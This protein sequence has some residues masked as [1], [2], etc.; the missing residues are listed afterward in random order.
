L[1]I[2]QLLNEIPMLADGFYHGDV[3][4]AFQLALALDFNQ[5]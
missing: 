5:E 2:R 1:A 4:K 3:D